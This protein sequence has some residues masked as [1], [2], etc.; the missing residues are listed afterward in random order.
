MTNPELTRDGD[1]MDGIEMLVPVVSSPVICAWHPMYHGEE[2]ILGT[3]AA[4]EP[5]HGICRECEVIL[6]AQHQAL[7]QGR[8]A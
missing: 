6:M 8:A 4:S 1:M 2:L 5:S 7:K 3:V